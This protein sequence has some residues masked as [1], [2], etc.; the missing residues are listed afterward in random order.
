MKK[1]YIKWIYVIVWAVIIFLFSSQNGS[2]SNNNN[3]F[4]IYI[5]NLIGFNLD[6]LLGNMSNFIVRKLGHFS[7]YFIFYYLLYNALIEDVK[8]KKALILSFIIMSLYACTDEIHQAFMPGRG[9]AVRDV[10]V[11]MG[12]GTACLILKLLRKK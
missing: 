6:S 7:E 12:G 10:L 11:D 9:P 8:H 4:I 3:R 1:K 2:S 5:L